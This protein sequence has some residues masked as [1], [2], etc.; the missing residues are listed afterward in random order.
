MDGY[1]Y[2]IKAE[3]GHSAREV[4]RGSIAHLATRG[5]EHVNHRM[6]CCSLYLPVYQEQTRVNGGF[7]RWSLDTRSKA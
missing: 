6:L 7:I 2:A 3:D 4:H 1:G 5:C